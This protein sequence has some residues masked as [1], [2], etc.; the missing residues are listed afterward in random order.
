MFKI[1]Q[2]AVDR[3]IEDSARNHLLMNNEEIFNTQQ[4][5]FNKVTK[6]HQLIL[7]Y[8]ASC[9][10][11]QENELLFINQRITAKKIKIHHNSIYSILKELQEDS[12]TCCKSINNQ[13]RIKL[14][15]SRNSNVEL[16]LLVSQEFSKYLNQKRDQ[17]VTLGKDNEYENQQNNAYEN[18]LLEKQINYL[19]KHK[20]ELSQKLAK[21]LVGTFTDAENRTL[22]VLDNSDYNVL[23]IE[24]LEN[25][26]TY[27]PEFLISK[28]PSRLQEKRNQLRTKLNKI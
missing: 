16:L 15:L 17:E 7:L 24:L 2:E 25:I 4:R 8:L 28:L 22:T 12:K 13:V 14:D 1:K 20:K 26:S 5:A 27:L 11:I 10:V 9:L 21:D 18:K 23:I 6:T 19:R 3:L